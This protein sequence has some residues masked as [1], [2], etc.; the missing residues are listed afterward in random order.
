MR[1][2]AAATSQAPEGPPSELKS[3]PKSRDTTIQAEVLF[4]EARTHAVPSRV[5]CTSPLPRMHPARHCLC[6]CPRTAYARAKSVD[7]MGTVP[8]VQP[9]QPPR[10]RSDCAAVPSVR[11]SLRSDGGASRGQHLQRGRLRVELRGL[12]KREEEASGARTQPRLRRAAAAAVEQV[13]LSV[14]L[15]TLMESVR[16]GADLRALVERVSLSFNP[17]ASVVTLQNQQRVHM[18]HK[19]RAHQVDE[20]ARQRAPAQQRVHMHLETW[21]HQVDKVRIGVL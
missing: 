1:G 8:P 14:D 5:G 6:T 19:T 3:A 4:R 16:F 11:R 20:L 13:R 9:T 21:A 12:D 18:H 17:P 10:R 15:H 7:S 2:Q